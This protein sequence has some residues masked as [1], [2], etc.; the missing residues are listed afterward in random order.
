M[1]H[2]ET[3]HGLN[4]V[5]QVIVSTYFSLV[6]LGIMLVG[7][8]V[9][10]VSRFREVNLL[11]RPDTLGAVIS[12]MAGS[13]LDYVDKTEHFDDSTEN[14]E[15]QVTEMRYALEQVAREDGQLAWMVIAM[16]A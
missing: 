3:R 4:F 15:G 7:A 11:R 1:H 14:D 2:F 13:R 12:Y 9:L 16:P 6:S 8:V 10:I 5:E